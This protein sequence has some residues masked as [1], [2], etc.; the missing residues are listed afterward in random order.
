MTATSESDVDSGDAWIPDTVAYRL[1]T[2]MQL[3]EASP[4]RRNEAY[5]EIVLSALKASNI[6]VRAL[7]RLCF[8]RFDPEAGSYSFSPRFGMTG[9]EMEGPSLRTFKRQA[10]KKKAKTY[11]S[12]VQSRPPS[13]SSAEE[14]SSSCSSPCPDSC[15]LETSALGSSRTSSMMEREEEGEDL[16]SWASQQGKGE[17]DQTIIGASN[18][19]SA[20]GFPLRP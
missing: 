6:A 9:R 11:G 1:A 18:R 13:S 16:S 20:L 3:G 12:F 15:D 19:T 8:W 2:L 10:R 5:F 14:S 7:P 4:T 17:Q